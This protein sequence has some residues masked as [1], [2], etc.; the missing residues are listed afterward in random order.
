M[1]FRIFRARFMPK[2]ARSTSFSLS[3]S[4]GKVHRVFHQTFQTIH[5]TRKH[6]VSDYRTHVRI[7]LFS[8][9][10]KKTRHGQEPNMDKPWLKKLYVFLASIHCFV[11]NSNDITM[12]KN[13]D[14]FNFGN[15]VAPDFSTKSWSCCIR[16]SMAWLWEKWPQSVAS[17][18]NIY[19]IEKTGMKL[20][21]KHT[22]DEHFEWLFLTPTFKVELM[23]IYPY[24]KKKSRY[25]INVVMSFQV[26]CFWHPASLG[27]RHPGLSLW[28]SLPS[29]PLR[30]ASSA[31]RPSLCLAVCFYS[32]LAKRS[33]K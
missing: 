31:R 15:Q 22:N 14:F 26:P 33:Y 25:T 28:R 30:G 5:H 8:H 11:H 4:L 1:L 32:N 17:G 7:S 24:W 23:V 12:D 27:Q 19:C 13:N 10:F 21:M 20:L 16:T 6:T 29:S 2:L 3:P 18:T 9:G